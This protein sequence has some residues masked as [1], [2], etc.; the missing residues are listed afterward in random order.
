MWEDETNV[1]S[2]LN[3]VQSE[4]LCC[5]FSKFTLSWT[6]MLSHSDSLPLPQLGSLR[7]GRGIRGRAVNYITFSGP[8]SPLVYDSVLFTWELLASGIHSRSLF[9]ALLIIFYLLGKPH[10]TT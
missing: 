3:F 7:C 1:Q 9:L 5:S 10:S 4:R 8:L 6:H 2:S